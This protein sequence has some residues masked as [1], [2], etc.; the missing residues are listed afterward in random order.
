MAGF[1]IISARGDRLPLVG[2]P[3][4]ELINIEGQTENDNAL[5]SNTTVG[6]DGDTVNGVATNPRPIVI[7]LYI[8]QNVEQT[9]RYILSY[10]KPK[11]THTL[12][13]E[14]ENRTLVISGVVQKITMPRWQNGIVM[15]I[16]LHC[17]QPY[18]EDAEAV[19][20]EVSEIVPLH[21]FTTS[22]N[23]MLYFDYDDDGISFGE[24]DVART[25]T[26]YNSGDVAVGLEIVVNALKTVTNPIIYA[27]PDKFIGANITLN[28]G[29]TLTI[30]TGRGNKDIRKD[31]VSVIGNIMQGSTFLQLET[32]DN[33]FTI[34][35]DETDI[36]NMYFEIIYS[37]R[38]V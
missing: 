10:V 24:Y 16:T 6:A 11:Q 38:Y 29:E 12:E 18:W 3:R 27:S 31:G 8:T 23:D 20:Q 19:V 32:G 36:D 15:Q 1:T 14:Q 37:Q 22:D 26:F 21:Y 5:Y 2:N 25:K 13:W 35:S 34:D 9:K 33:T 4:F 28:A 7:Y 30:T 17:G